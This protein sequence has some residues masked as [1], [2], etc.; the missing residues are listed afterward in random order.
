MCHTISLSYKRL[1]FFD[2]WNETLGILRKLNFDSNPILIQT[3]CDRH[4]PQIAWHLKGRNFSVVV[5]VRWCHDNHGEDLPKTWNLACIWVFPKIGV[6]HGWFIM[7]NPI[8]MDDLGVPLFL[9]TP[10]WSLDISLNLPSM[11]NSSSHH[12]FFFA[13]FLKLFSSFIANLSI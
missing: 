10:I 11:A 8:K 6:S 1:G 2:I 3:C 4:Q 7:E 9:E 5:D 12:V 13:N